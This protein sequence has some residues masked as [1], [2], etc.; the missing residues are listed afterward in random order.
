M[1]ATTGGL[2][3]ELDKANELCWQATEETVL[4]WK[5]SEGY[6]VDV[7]VPAKGF[8]RRK[9]IKEHTQYNTESLAK[10][11]FSIL[12]RAVKFSQQN[13]VPILLDY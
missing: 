7:E 2:K 10:Y 6:P 5:D 8:W 9:K 4:G 11:A 13:R 3:A 1:I 12:W